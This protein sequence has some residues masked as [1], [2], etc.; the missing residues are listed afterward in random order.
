[1]K[2]QKK[3]DSQIKNVELEEEEVKPCPFCGSADIALCNTHTAAYWMECQDCGAQVDG[4]SYASLDDDESH[5]A[6]AR[7]ALEAWNHRA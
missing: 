1:M 5:L 4:H 7:S 2:I 3:A 6:S